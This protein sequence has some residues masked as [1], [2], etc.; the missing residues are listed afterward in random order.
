[1][2]D[3]ASD[4]SIL[5]LISLCVRAGLLKAGEE[6]C[7][8][9]LRKGETKL[10]IISR[11]ASGNT[12]KKF[13]NKARYY[14]VPVVIYGMKHELGKLTGAGVSASLCVTDHNLGGKIKNAIE[15][16]E[17][18]EPSADAASPPGGIEFANI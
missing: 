2:S 16:F 11:D 18:G 1:M 12:K 4:K 17:C 3:G 15:H 14:N 6:K 13:T 8:K 5:S 9:A 10:V 7:E